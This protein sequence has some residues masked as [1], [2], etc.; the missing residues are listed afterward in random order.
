MFQCERCGSSYSARHTVAIS[1]CPRCRAKDRIA[2]PLTFKAFGTV[3]SRAEPR[4]RSAP[5]YLER[6]LRA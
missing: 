6:G 5:S 1:D 4:P 2:S 3:D